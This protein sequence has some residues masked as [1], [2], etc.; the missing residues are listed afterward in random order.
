MC[1]IAGCLSANPIETSNIMHALGT[2]SRRGPDDASYKLFQTQNPKRQVALLHS[3]LSIIDL[4]DRA[5]QPFHLADKWIA[6]NGEI[7]NYLELKAE[8]EA[9]GRTFTTSSDT[10]VLA[11]TLDQWGISGLDKC[12]GMW[13][14][15]VYNETDQSIMLCRDRFGEKPL[16]FH[17]DQNGNIWF[18]SE[19]KTIAALSGKSFN[20][21][22][23]QLNRFLVNGY[24]SIFKNFETFFNGIEIVNPGTALVISP[25]SDR[26][27]I[28]YWSPQYKH[29]DSLSFVDATKQAREKLIK[30]VELRLR[31][32]VPLAFCMSGGV[33]SNSLISIAKRELDYDVHGFTVV[34]TDARYEEQDLVDTVVSELSLRHTNVNLNKH[35]FLEGMRELVR[36][37]DAP[38]FT[39]TYYVHWLLQKQMAEQ[40]YKISI[41][42]T[43][44]D[45][46]FSGYFDH[47]NFYLYDV[48][49]DKA[50]FSKS[51]G[52]WQN[53]IGK[54][55]RNPFLQDPEVFIKNP[56]ER[57]HIYLDSDV[58]SSYLTSP[59]NEPFQ[60]NIY[61]NDSLLQNRM[62]NEIFHEATP[63]ILHED[64]LNSMYYSIE[65]RSPFLDRKLFEFCNSIP[66]Q[67][68]IQNGAAKAVLRESMRGIVPDPVLDSVRKV[69]FNAPISD[70]IDLED[71][72]TRS[73]LLSDSPIYEHV[74]RKKI[75]ELLQNKNLTN[76]KSK[77]IF[78]F[79]SSKIFLEENFK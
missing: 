17:D 2:M 52:N 40:G 18:S 41:S 64:D 38:V 59:W 75:T 14:F 62:L 72:N 29:D 47:Q 28:R 78:S 20:L 22:V 74:C 54:Y 12:E 24:K 58:F 73:E 48:H 68:L 8:L 63:V 16:Y 67:Y 76:S 49:N 51:L 56:Q 66:A 35:G 37:H 30:S 77:F 1:G 42:G 6:F 26:K 9:L 60:E 70:L 57:N 39:I 61:R 7:Y 53:N 79:I 10:E 55:V 44:A 69:G 46:L 5:N 43:A 33:D 27:I 50:Q 32:D 13:S 34:N 25:N 11:H 4:H 15:A 31:A 36:Y 23:N 71:K 19:I 65:N 3:R 45:E 21:N